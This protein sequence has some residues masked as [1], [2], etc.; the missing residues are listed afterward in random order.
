MADLCF[1]NGES[2]CGCKIDFHSGYGEYS[3]VLYVTLCG[4][5][6]GADLINSLYAELELASSPAE[7]NSI[8]VI[9]SAL[10]MIRE[11]KAKGEGE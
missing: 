5:H 2:K 4:T 6:S 3:D 1:V 10:E 11:Y 9:E 8:N 7:E